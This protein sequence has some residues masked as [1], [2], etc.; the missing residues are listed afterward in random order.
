MGQV[1]KKK[2][3]I[4]DD[5]KIFRINPDSTFTEV[6]VTE[7]M[8]ADNHED[9]EIINNFRQEIEI[10]SK[11][12][13]HE[14]TEKDKLSL[15]MTA[16]EKEN[17]KLISRINALESAKGSTSQ[18]GRKKWI[19]T[20]AVFLVLLAGVG[21]WGYCMLLNFNNRDYQLHAFKE[22]ATRQGF[23]NDSTGYWLDLPTDT[24]AKPQPEPKVV[25]KTETKT[26]VE[27]RTP[28]RFRK[29]SIDYAL[30]TPNLKGR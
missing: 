10:L 8:P 6:F 26:V 13:V 9:S 28:P 23:Y 5:G 29:S 30:V 21:T 27:Y 15:N 4:T 12:Y 16:L 7:K 17:R 25:T 22:E 24:E 2:Y 14:K 3:H 19:I 18:K 11:Q 20:M 1:D